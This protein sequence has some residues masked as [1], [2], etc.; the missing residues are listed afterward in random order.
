MGQQMGRGGIHHPDENRVFTV[1][2]L[3]RL[4]GL[5]DDFTLTGTFNQKA[6]RCGRMVTP[7]TYKYLGKSL[8]EKVLNPARH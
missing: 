6:E 7:P 8:Y 5:P 1:M 2:E 4:M 3:K